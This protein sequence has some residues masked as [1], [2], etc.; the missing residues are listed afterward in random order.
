SD[1]GQELNSIQLLIL[2]DFIRSWYADYSY[3]PQFLKDTKILLQQTFNS[4]V[5]RIA[6]QDPDVTLTRIL[7]LFM[8]HLSNFLKAQ[9]SF[10]SHKVHPNTKVE[11][12]STVMRHSSVDEA[13]KSLSSFHYALDSERLE[14][15]Y[16]KGV[17]SVIVVCACNSQVIKGVCARTLL[18]DILSQNIMLPLVAMISD[19]LWLMKIIIRITSYE[20]EQTESGVHN[21]FDIKVDEVEIPS[22][23]KKKD[24]NTGEVGGE[25]DI[26][27]NHAESGVEDSVNLNNLKDLEIFLPSHEDCG[28]SESY[29]KA[30][31]SEAETVSCKTTSPVVAQQTRD[32][33][34]P[35]ASELSALDKHH[36]PVGNVSKKESDNQ[37]KSNTPD[38]SH[39]HISVRNPECNHN[40][41][42][43]LSSPLIHESEADVGKEA[44]DHFSENNYDIEDMEVD[45]QKIISF[46]SSMEPSASN[47][48]Y[49]LDD[50]RIFQ[51][52]SI[53]ETIVN[54]EY[55]SS[56]QYSL[57]IIQYEAL[58]FS[59]E[60]KS[61]I[62]SGTVRRR[63]REFL[64]LQSRLES[65]STYKQ[66][67]KKIRGPKR[68]PSLPFKTLDKET[69]EA[70]RLF[71]EKYLKDLIE[72]EAICNS[73]DIREFLAYEGD[74]H[75]AFVKK[76]PEINVPRLDKM[77][78]RGVSGVVD[79]I[80]SIPN[81]AQ[82][83]ISG[84]RSRETPE[85]RPGSKSAGQHDTDMF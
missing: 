71:L 45:P 56:N 40:I 42:D 23:D 18:V 35:G 30:E 25:K 21:E 68:W 10:Q 60:G 27:Q 54:T 66:F 78:M 69:V 15:D 9:N 73:P 64:N 19:P 80:M 65:Q 53:P 72:I 24:S 61:I 17:M 74:S 48:S 81:N 16:V 5:S 85:D 28:D 46:S 63:Y 1:V 26:K 34:D 67:L 36:Q 13:F 2:R 37:G 50:R 58:Y 31:G 70:R 7:K 52:V 8:V 43:K 11:T 83:V 47:D 39:N 20:E 4:L 32:E 62:R 51:D 6:Q 38:C 33:I 41:K 29:D 22:L 82:E 3:D 75:I 84:L 76:S 55:R 79:R 57:Y 49:I 44:M 12:G 59:E 77:L 14:Q